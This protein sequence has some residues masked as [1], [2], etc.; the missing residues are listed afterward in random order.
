[1]V[2]LWFSLSIVNIVFDIITNKIGL[3]YVRKVK[4]CDDYK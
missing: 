4:L 1:M 2:R 3:E